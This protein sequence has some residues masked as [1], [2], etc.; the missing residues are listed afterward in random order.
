VSESNAVHWVLMGNG[1]N[2]GNLVLQKSL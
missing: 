1:N 2:T